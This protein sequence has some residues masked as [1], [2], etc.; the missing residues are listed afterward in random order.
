MEL[1]TDRRAACK[2][3]VEPGEV[4]Y[5]P[6]AGLQLAR[7]DLRDPGILDQRGLSGGRERVAAAL[8]PEEPRIVVLL[9]DR[10]GAGHAAALPQRGGRDAARALCP[11]A[12]SRRART[13]SSVPRRC[14]RTRGRRLPG[15]FGRVRRAAQRRAP[16]PRPAA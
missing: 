12:R 6:G 4:R 8:H 15:G 16:P 10:S 1:R 3:P 7:A 2:R 14:C 5:R 11:A 13:R 9:Q